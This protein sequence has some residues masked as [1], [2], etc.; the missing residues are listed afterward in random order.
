VSQFQISPQGAVL[1][2]TAQGVH[3]EVSGCVANV[4]KTI[5]FPKP[6]GGGLVQVRYPFTFR[7]TG[8]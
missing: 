2:S 5:Q 7:P 4:I 6:R 8:G 1:N 3:D